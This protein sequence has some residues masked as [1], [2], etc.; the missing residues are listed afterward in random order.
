MGVCGEER[1][2]IKINSSVQNSSVN[3]SN[4]NIR[5]EV[6][7]PKVKKVNFPELNDFMKNNEIQDSFYEYE[8]DPIYEELKL[9]EK[10]ELTSIFK[11][12]LNNYENLLKARKINFQVNNL[13][14]EI[15]KKENTELIFKD[16]I[17]KEIEII[18]ENNDNPKYNINYLT[19][20]LFGT[21]GVGKTE[22]V[23]YIFKKK[24]LNDEIIS[25]KLYDNNLI[26]YESNNNEIKLKLLEYKGYGI[27]EGSNP[28]EI[29]N[30]TKDYIKN[31]INKKKEN[32]SNFNDF[33][34]C[35]WFCITGTRLQESEIITLKGL[36]TVYGERIMP[37]IIVYTNAADSNN[38]SEMKKFIASD[39][40][41]LKD[42]IKEEDIVKINSKEFKL[43]GTNEYIPPF[44]GDNLLNKTLT[45]CTQSLEGE[46]KIIMLKNISNNIIEK[47]KLVNCE[48]EKKIKKNII[49]EYITN[50]KSVKKDQE[51]I[52]Y[53]VHI[54]GNNLKEF[55]PKNKISNGSLNL[56]YNNIKNIEEYINFFKNKTKEII[57]KVNE[58]KAKIFL[59][60]QAIKE[61]T[62]KQNIEIKN[63]RN[64]NKFM[65]T[66][67]VFL[68]KNFYYIAQKIIV[69]DFINNFVIKFLEK[70]RK[71][72]DSFIITLMNINEKKMYNDKEINENLNYC[73][74][75]KLKNFAEKI[76]IPLENKNNLKVSNI[77]LPYE[78]E[79]GDEIL[80]KNEINQDS[81]EIYENNIEINKIKTQKIK[82]DNNWFPLVSKKEK[83][84][85]L[86]E[87][88]LNSLYKFLNNM[89]YQDTYFSTITNDNTFFAMKKSGKK[90]LI[91]FLEDN[92]RKFINNIYNKNKTDIKF[93]KN[94]RQIISSIL[95]N[96]IFTN[97][98][99]NKIK[100]EFKKLTNN[101]NFSKIDYI[102]TLVMGKSGIGKSTLINKLLN[103]KDKKKMKTGVGKI[104]TINPTLCSN[105]E[106]LYLKFIDTRGIEL[107][108]IYGPD[109]IFEEISKFINS[110]DNKNKN[111]KDNVN[112]IWYCV[113]GNVIEDKE[114]EII[115]KLNKDQ[116]SIPIIVVYTYSKNEES[117]NKLK[118]E[119]N[120]LFQGE[121]HF[122]SILSKGIKNEETGAIS[123]PFGL[124]EL[125]ELTFERCKKAIQSKIF[126]NIKNETS[127]ELKNIFNQKNTQIKKELN[128]NIVSFFIN[129]YN[130]VLEDDKFIEI[131]FLYFEK[132]LIGFFEINNNLEKDTNELKNSNEFKKF[133]NIYIQDYKTF[134]K[135]I[136]NKKFLEEKS[137]EFLDKQ[138]NKEIKKNQN[139]DI[140]NKNNKVNFIN[141]IQTFLNNNFYFIGQKYLIYRLITDV[142]NS[143]SN[144]ISRETNNQIGNII[145]QNNEI[146]EMFKD[147]YIKKIEDLLKK[148]KNFYKNF[149]K[150]DN[151]INY[152]DE[153]KKGKNNS[154]N[155]ENS[156]EN[157]PINYPPAS[158]LNSNFDK[159]DKNLEYN[160]I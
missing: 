84:D 7:V 124:V 115:K 6:I 86:S 18:K 63:K 154:Y 16:K 150:N 158:I 92:K 78:N 76:N 105:K 59:N 11:I 93:D 91:N 98:L 25:K 128:N 41:G 110:K 29:G 160:K 64:L 82:E 68:K 71:K 103:L 5:R 146:K 104:Q 21:T 131:I 96:E 8:N 51:F 119:I 40:S 28:K 151:F 95:K 140:E 111:I 144:D 37:I 17:L 15:L 52:D 81:F 148:C 38:F 153:D 43:A 66:N 135:T 54:L 113:S 32:N 24:D 55:Y 120:E 20:L 23:N 14:Q 33:V 65:R 67:E 62:G 50:Y 107:N 83:M 30:K 4:T 35:I 125:I 58:E 69:N 152:E 36:K 48:N 133:L 79:V 45:K 13:E 77:N 134:T 130:K 106:V 116:K 126:K 74:F 34:H 137:I 155:E 156:S 3:S 159:K 123:K 118:N 121:V 149:L 1:K 108:K 90:N 122:I 2:K 157:N 85:Y 87:D 57:Q 39:E 27:G 102:T 31:L 44:G 99:Q 129:N 139:I 114:I 22:L 60:E 117:I 80:Y 138:V 141:I 70:F 97:T 143:F 136:V 46:M 142:F 26:K 127:Q 49:N 47:M 19:I 53:L 42:Y 89:N 73:Y 147:I 112:C 109:Q 100:D 145:N 101:K 88:L 10:T 72:I 132:F 12:K 61:I 94:Q 56:I 9:F 75:I